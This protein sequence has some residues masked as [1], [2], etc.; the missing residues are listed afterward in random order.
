MTDLTYREQF[1]DAVSSLVI[2]QER[3]GLDILTNGD[4]HLDTSLGGGSW[5]LY[6]AERVGGVDRANV[7]QSSGEWAYSAGTMLHEIMGGW[8]YPPVVGEL[9][10]GIAFEFDKAWRV[11]QQR[12]DKPVKFGTVSAQLAASIMEIKTDR[13]D[14]DKRQLMWD[15]ST[16]MNQE[17]RALAAA[18]CKCIQV[19]EPMMH[20]IAATNPDPELNEFLI[21]CLNHE[22][23]GLDDVEVWVHTC[24]GNPNMQR[25]LKDTTYR[26]VF[27]VYLGRVNCDV[28]TVEMKDRDFVDLELFGN[29]RESARKIAVGIV[30]H[31]TLQADSAEDVADDVRRCLKYID[32]EKLILTTD[33]G[34]G[35][36]GCNRLTAFYKTVAIVEGA[37]IV[38]RE[39]GVDAPPARV[40][41]P[42]LQV[43]P[44]KDRSLASTKI[45]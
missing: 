36:Q 40:Q 12:T 7:E 1:T 19:E 22:L 16:I 45:S 17:L 21:E 26:D 14:E 32:P 5:L 35:R 9:G 13:Y 3:A 4:Y 25:V 2:D 31:R 37:N 42:R 18:G 20:F 6:P 23:S 15:F 30:S 44:E 24:W 41:D 29:H 34:F 10:P 27:D 8:R 33:C 11:A 39:L 43:D 28:W 38:R